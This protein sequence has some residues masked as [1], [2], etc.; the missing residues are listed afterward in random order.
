MYPI[1]EQSFGKK[2]FS[3]LTQQRKL[4]LLYGNIM[5][6]IIFM[7]YILMCIQTHTLLI[8]LKQLLLYYSH[9]IEIIVLIGLQYITS[10]LMN[11]TRWIQ[12]LLL[13]V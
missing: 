6:L 5:E 10:Y 13:W 12:C 11:F 9:Y 4:L 8:E 1:R 2:L 3:G 7:N